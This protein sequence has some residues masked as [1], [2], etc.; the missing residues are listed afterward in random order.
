MQTGKKE[1]LWDATNAKDTPPS[2][3]PVAEQGDRE[4]QKLW[5]KVTKALRERDQE[6]ATDEKS[7]IEDMQRREAAE[8]SASGAEWKPSLF[9]AIEEAPEGFNRDEKDLDW[10]INAKM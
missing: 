5:A 1:L 7:A 3:R 6:V 9:C 10:I 2:V 4:S 8:R